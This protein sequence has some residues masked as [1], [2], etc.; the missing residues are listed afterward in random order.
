MIWQETLITRLVDR[1]ENHHL[2]TDMEPYRQRLEVAAIETPANAAVLASMHRNLWQLWQTGFTSHSSIID[3]SVRKEFR[4][5]VIDNLAKDLESK[6]SPALFK[7]TSVLHNY[8]ILLAG[9]HQYEI[10]RDH[11]PEAAPDEPSRRK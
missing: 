8:W 7:G 9:I 10:R 2:L 4:E 3:D 5:G 6:V 1:I 11:P